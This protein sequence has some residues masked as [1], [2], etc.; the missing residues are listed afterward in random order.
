VELAEVVPWGRGLNEYKAMFSLSDNDLKKS[1]LGCGD[2]PAS[3]NAELSKSGHDIVSVDPI[4]QFNSKEI[5]SRI[6]EV[7]PQIMS[8]VA[9]N[10]EDY[11]WKNIAN[12]EAMGSTRMAAMQSFL[13]DYAQGKKSGRYINA[14]LPR[15]PFKNIEFELALCSHY[16]F[17]YSE[18]VNQKQHLLSMKELCRVAA[19][20]RVYPL[21]SISNN[22]ISPHL[23]SV[24][25]GLKNCDL[26]V[27][28]VPVEYEFQKGANEMLVV[29]R[30]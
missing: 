25:S 3:F 26:S 28:L 14:S 2:G 5:R 18:Q 7:Y 9:K 21:L 8:Q 23:T 24:I 27:S 11:V 15:L 17:L 4:Y 29:K 30:V 1:I 13:A 16:L 6:D 10:T 20:V 22:Q 19:E 12:F